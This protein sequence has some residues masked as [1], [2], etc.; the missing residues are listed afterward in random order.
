[1]RFMMLVKAS[2]ESEAGVMPPKEDFV[3][4]GKYNEELNKAGVLLALDGLH[5]SSRGVRV[6]FAGGKPKVIDGPFAE[7]KELLAGFWLIDVKS[8]DE[9]IEWAKRIP[10]DDG[11]VEVRQ[12]FELADMPPD[13][14]SPDELAKK[15]AARGELARRQREELAQMQKGE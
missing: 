5:P 11:V 10:F 7:T 15:E 6:D 13:I 2:E 9:A 1:M 14:L 8:R 12:V 4:M 3:R